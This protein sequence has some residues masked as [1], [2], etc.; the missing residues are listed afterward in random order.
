MRFFGVLRLL[1]SCPSRSA[2]I[3]FG[4]HLT[5]RPNLPTATFR[6]W[7]SKI[8]QRWRI[9]ALS[10]RTHIKYETVLR[11]H[12]LPS[13]AFG[14]FSQ[15]AYDKFGDNVQYVESQKVRGAHTTNPLYI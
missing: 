11:A 4:H 3:S 13:D 14:R 15:G 10:A 6:L 1:V 2:A 7:L 8:V 5:Q 12:A 9:W